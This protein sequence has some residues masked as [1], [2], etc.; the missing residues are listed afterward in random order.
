MSFW[1]IFL[2]ASVVLNIW[3]LI[4][5]AS[6]QHEIEKQQMKINRMKSDLIKRK[7]W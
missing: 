5:W 7:K 1:I 4:L 2:S 3:L 6:Q